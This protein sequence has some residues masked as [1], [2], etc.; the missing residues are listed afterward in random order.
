MWISLHSQNPAWALLKFGITWNLSLGSTT[1]SAQMWNS[2]EFPHGL[3]HILIWSLRS[4]SAKPN[5]QQLHRDPCPSST[6]SQFLLKLYAN[7]CSSPSPSFKSITAQVWARSLPRLSLVS[8]KLEL[9]CF[10]SLSSISAWSLL[11]LEPDRFSALS[12]IDF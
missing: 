9:D 11:K 4:I 7:L 5:L 12:S 6:V 2:L 3:E 8:S 10:S 1:I